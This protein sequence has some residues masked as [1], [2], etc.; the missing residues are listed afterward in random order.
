MPAN[1]GILQRTEGA[2]S[3][4]FVRPDTRLFG[5]WND[6]VCD[7]LTGGPPPMTLSGPKIFSN[8]PAQG[9]AVS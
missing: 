1:I 4:A 7:Y 6:R 8:E 3:D 5:R 9:V 2:K